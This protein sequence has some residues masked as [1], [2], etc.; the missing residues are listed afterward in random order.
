MVSL[1]H[2]ICYQTTDQGLD[3]IFRVARSALGPG[4]VFVFDFWHGPAVLAQGPEV[5]ERRVSTAAADV[6]RQAEPTHHASR[7]VVDVRYTLT[8][9]D[10]KSG[11]LEQNA[12]IHSVRYLFLP[13]IL[14]LAARNGFT[15]AESGEWLTQKPLD[16]TSW[17]GY[18]ALKAN[19][20]LVAATP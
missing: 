11:H 13:E 14:A 4:G 8:V 3:S 2:V 16:E 17:S 15:L 19:E 1:F 20:D 12:E 10:R 18:V 5:R 7:H 9:L 6:T